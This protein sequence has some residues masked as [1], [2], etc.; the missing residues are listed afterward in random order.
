MKA[1]DQLRQN[2]RDLREDKHLTQAVMA[3]KLGMS[4]TG[5]AKIERGETAIKVERLQQ[6]ANVL[7][8][9][10]AELLPLGEGVLVFNNS[11]DNF[12]NSSNFNLNLGNPALESEITNLHQL[13]EAKNEI[14]S[15]RERE[16]ATLK[17]Q[18]TIL[19]K[20]VHTLE[21]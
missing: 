3:E 11:N 17:S 1:S 12:S 20:L 19:E 16:I 21:K 14:I 5:Y 18:I 10:I 2:I 13:I 6:I 7:E 4:E 8:V 15:S 9:N